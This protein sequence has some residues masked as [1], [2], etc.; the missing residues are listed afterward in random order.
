MQWL[1][2]PPL[3]ALRAFSALAECRTMQA[4]GEAL[5]V[6]HAAISQQVKALEE[7][8]GLALVVRG[9]RKL[10][11]TDDGRLLAEALERGFGEIEA[12]VTQLT[13]RTDARAL[14]ITTTPSFAAGWLLPKL[15]DFRAKHAQ[16]DLMMNATPEAV[17]LRPGGTDL[18]VRYGAGQW[19]GCDAELLIPTDIVVVAAP[20]LIGDRKIETPAELS[21]FDWISEQ[22]LHEASNWLRRHGVEDGRA[23]SITHMSG[24]MML[25]AARLGQGVVCTA[26]LFVQDDIARGRLSLLYEE[27][28]GAA[29]SGYFLVTRQGAVLRPVAKAF[30][31]WLRL[32]AK[33]DAAKR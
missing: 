5:N 13:G 10:S 25:D 27:P 28:Q 31:S 4:A 16:V 19:D 29:Q 2:L 22:G 3:T 33:A 32:M 8:M 1:S 12:T 17:A 30:A 20:E 21:A 6:S 23:K 26:R 14:Q 11:L 24:N 7:H 9:G 18:A 15:A